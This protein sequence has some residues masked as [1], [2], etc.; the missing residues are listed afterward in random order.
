MKNVSTLFLVFIALG[1]SACV[2]KGADASFAGVKTPVY[3]GPVQRIGSKEPLVAKK[4]APFAAEASREFR[5]YKSGMYEI[6]EMSATGRLQL[7]AAALEATKNANDTD[8]HLTDVK[9]VSRTYFL[10]ARSTQYVE[11]EGD[12]VKVQVA[13]E[14]AK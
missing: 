6:T 1:T 10:G 11:I 7:S 12:V 9:P 3:L 14:G 13:K 5:Q 2:F 8:I 4:I